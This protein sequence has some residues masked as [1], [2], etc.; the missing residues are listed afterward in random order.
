MTTTP[1]GRASA[2]A[3][4]TSSRPA[5]REWWQHLAVWRSRW[6]GSH[7]RAARVWMVARTVV[8]AGS[9]LWLLGLWLFLP[10]LRLGMRAYLGCLW[11]VVAWFALARTKTLTWSGYLG[12][13]ALCVP[14]SIGIGLVTTVMAGEVAQFDL[15]AVTE[16][17]AQVA[18]AGIVEEAAKLVPVAVLVLLAPRR[19]ARFATVDWLLLGLAS[20][21]A[22]LAVEESVRRT[23]LAT[24]NAGLGSLFGMTPDAVLPPGY[25]QFGLTPIPS[26]MSAEGALLAPTTAGEFGGHAIMTALVTGVV[27][28]AVAAWQARRR[29]TALALTAL[30]LVVLWS[31]IADHAM[32]NAGLELFSALPGDGD[33]P[34][35][36][37]PDSTTIPWWL[38]VPWSFLGHGHGRITVFL[39][40]VLVC[41]LV[42]AARLAARPAANLTGRPA[43]TWV[44]RPALGAPAMVNTVA[45]AITSLVWVVVRDLAQALAGHARRPPDDDE[46]VEPRR[47]AAARGATLISGQRTLRELAY[48]HAS[49]PIHP[50]AR[51]LAA[52]AV[53]AG[54]GWLVFAAAPATAREIGTSTND[55]Y[56]LPGL[57]PTDAPTGLPT[58]PPSG[59]PTDLPELP[60]QMPTGLP[61]VPPTDIPTVAP[62]D[63]PTFAPDDFPSLDPD[64][65]FPS[66]PSDTTPGSA[67]SPDQWL[68]GVLDALADWWHDQPLLAQL[69]IGAGIAALIVLSGGSL[70]LALGISGV[71]TWGLD[72]SAGIATFVR[73]PRQATRDYIATATPTQLAAD[74]LGVALTFAPGNFAGAATGRVLRNTADDLV[75]DPRLWWATRRDAFD[76]AD[77]T[78]AINPALLLKR[79]PRNPADL[80]KSH[81]YDLDGALY[82]VDDLGRPAGIETKLTK[83][84]IGGATDPKVTPLG[85]ADGLHS[86][87]LHGALLGGPNDHA[88]NFVAQYERA[89]NPWQRMIEREV[90]N[91]VK[92]GE[93]VAYKVTPRYDG[94]AVVPSTIRIQAEGSNGYR[95]DYT[96]PNKD[97]PLYSAEVKAGNLPRNEHGFRFGT[98]NRA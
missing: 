85:A 5:P 13:F 87:H 9:L 68:A 95:L 37:D 25:V 36:L 75:A 51:R 45:G 92:A 94:G 57:N 39:L 74:T 52:V 93:D 76:W 3:P 18:I 28:L 6:L 31:T 40:L 73:D 4:I 46:P 43:P 80:I 69:A 42:D 35:W 21:T 58:G 71:L 90:S 79:H 15:F 66:L 29:L 70:G 38:R 10:E 50:W 78:G 81:T 32:Y 55:Q 12:F 17:G 22:F 77:E 64:F 97:L 67:G 23:A 84:T 98:R 63:L 60:T 88:A 33:T 49:A 16:T 30:S 26:P 7:P 24:G 8:L 47:V 1:L 65:E 48:E 14:W 61:T 27:G 82:H 11:V 34:A 44:T 86:G 96:L 83:D 59:L 41:L 53:L 72:K 89:N 91:V 56:Q 2:S 20:G 19:A 54:L 62:S